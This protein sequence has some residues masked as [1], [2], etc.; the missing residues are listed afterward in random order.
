MKKILFFIISFLLIFTVA[1]AEEV[2]DEI[3][4]IDTNPKVLGALSTDKKE[5]K[6]GET[7]IISVKNI[8]T[9]YALE[10]IIITVEGKENSNINLKDLGNGNYEF[11]MPRAN[12]YVDAILTTVNPRTYDNTSLIII[13]LFASAIFLGVLYILKKGVNQFE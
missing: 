6:P 8:S 3:Y 9:G 1:K 12:V 10:S 7:V 13:L 4:K 5:A 11:I 2:V